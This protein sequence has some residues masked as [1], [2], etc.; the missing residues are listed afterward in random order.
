MKDTA[1]PSAIN[2]LTL[3]VGTLAVSMSGLLLSGAAAATQPGPAAE[4]RLIVH[5]GAVIAIPG[6]RALGPSTIVVR[7]GKIAEI[8]PG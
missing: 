3:C 7:E 2:R 6:E 1:K 4:E 8:R 5:A